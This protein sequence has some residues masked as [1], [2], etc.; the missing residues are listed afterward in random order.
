MR[1]LKNGRAAYMLL[2]RNLV[3]L[4]E[5][6]FLRG[7]AV[8]A[9]QHNGAARMHATQALLNFHAAC[10]KQAYTARSAKKRAC[11]QQEIVHWHRL[12][13]KAKHRFKQMNSVSHSKY[14]EEV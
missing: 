3:T 6:N 8:P 10:L 13:E 5:K 9:A 1:G 11:V 7:R 12:C 4:C 2:L 14:S